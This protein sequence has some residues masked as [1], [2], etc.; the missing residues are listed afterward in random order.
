MTMEAEALGVWMRAVIA[1]LQAN[2]VWQQHWA[3]KALQ[4][5]LLK[6]ASTGKVTQADMSVACRVVNLDYGIDLHEHSS[7]GEVRLSMCRDRRCGGGAG[8]AA[9]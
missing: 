8:E 7:D 6:C 4:A 2:T 5:T 3:T 1:P 9:L